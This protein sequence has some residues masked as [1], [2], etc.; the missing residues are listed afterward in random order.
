ML[1]PYHKAGR[2]LK[3]LIVLGFGASGDY[4]TEIQVSMTIAGRDVEE[5]EYRPFG[6]IKDGYPRHLFTDVLDKAEKLLD[7]APRMAA[8]D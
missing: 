6:H 4:V 7:A 5:R 3:K 2:I 1:S 8:E